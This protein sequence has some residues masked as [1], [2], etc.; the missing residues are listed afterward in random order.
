M[1]CMIFESGNKSAAEPA[2]TTSDSDNCHNCKESENAQGNYQ[3]DECMGLRI[4]N[5]DVRH[6]LLYSSGP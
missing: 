6:E 1:L 4:I 5:D 3:S 2:C